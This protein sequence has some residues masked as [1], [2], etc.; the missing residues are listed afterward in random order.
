MTNYLESLSE[1]VAV[2]GTIA[3]VIVLVSMCFNTLTIK[4]ERWMRVLNL[5]GSVLSVVYG[6]ML[7]PQGFGMLILNGPLVVVNVYYLYRSYKTTKKI[8]NFR[9]ISK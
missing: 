8:F 2:V 7:G 3:S 1:P 9:D 4:G 5:I 6:V